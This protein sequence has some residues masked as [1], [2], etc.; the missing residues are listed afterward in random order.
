MSLLRRWS[1]EGV[2]KEGEIRELEEALAKAKA[3]LEK[4]AEQQGEEDRKWVEGVGEQRRGMV[5]RWRR[6]AG[7]ENE[8]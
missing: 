3:V 2:S 4:W 6:E 7:I 1:M 8:D 5:A